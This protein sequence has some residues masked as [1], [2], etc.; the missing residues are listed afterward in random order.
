MTLFIEIIL[1]NWT[2]TKGN[3]LNNPLKLESLKYGDK[4]FVQT[5]VT[6]TDW[7]DDA[8]KSSTTQNSTNSCYLAETSGRDERKHCISGSNG[9]GK[10]K[11]NS[12]VCF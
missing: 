11:E 3:N 12:D 9:N 10:T 7:R 8:N 6:E 4:A 5:W 2:K 1:T